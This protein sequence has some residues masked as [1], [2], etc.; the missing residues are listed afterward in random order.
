MKYRTGEYRPSGA[1]GHPDKT[2]LLMLYVVII[3]PV[4][5]MVS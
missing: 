4:V 2:F 5:E 1:H 3:T